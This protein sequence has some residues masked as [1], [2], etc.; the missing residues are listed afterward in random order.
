MKEILLFATTW[1][2]LESIMLTYK[3]LY[4]EI[5][6]AISPIL[7]LY[8]FPIQVSLYIQLLRFQPLY[9]CL[10][11]WLFLDC[12]FYFF[13]NYI[14]SRVF[15]YVQLKLY[16]VGKFFFEVLALNIALDF[17]K[18]LFPVIILLKHVFIISLLKAN[19]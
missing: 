10:Q 8:T 11:N 7:F 19:N 5:T 17:L 16:H 6:L 18:E 13:N 1:M 12:P 15:P 14:F 2:N 3:N 4:N 9:I